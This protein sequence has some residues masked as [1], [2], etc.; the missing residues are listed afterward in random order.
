MAWRLNKHFVFLVLILSTCF[1]GYAQL[2][3]DDSKWKEGRQERRYL[4]EEKEEEP[5]E[6]ESSP[7]SS[8]RAKTYNKSN[9][10]INE[11]AD[12][13]KMI[14][15]IIIIGVI[16][17]LIYKFIINNSLTTDKDEGLVFIEDLKEAEENLMKADLRKLLDKFLDE[18]DYR[19]AIRVQYLQIIQNLSKA[20]FIIWSKEKTNFEYFKEIKDLPFAGLY[21]ETTAIYERA[22][23][24][25]EMI[26]KERY[27]L[28]ITQGDKL[29]KQINE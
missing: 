15:F 8:G 6:E 13:I 17:F 19:S 10:N 21:M 23:F 7:S 29:N 9:F 5:E 28:M 27:T 4:E 14:F 20:K 22:W 25:R 16:I 26:N 2:N 24:G 11:T 3:L 12:L 1:G 18:G